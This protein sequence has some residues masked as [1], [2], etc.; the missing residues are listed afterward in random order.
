[1]LYLPRYLASEHIQQAAGKLRP[2]T[3]VH[4]RL[5]VQDHGHQWHEG[6]LTGLVI[7]YHACCYHTTKV[8]SQLHE[9]GRLAH[10]CVFL[11]PRGNGDMLSGTNLPQCRRLSSPARTRA[12][13]N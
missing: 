9:R 6:G 10:V 3:E 12:D 7:A 8:V 4:V 11:M 1:M 5:D 2:R 13:H